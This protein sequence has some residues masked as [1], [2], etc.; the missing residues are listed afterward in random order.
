M[1]GDGRRRARRKMRKTKGKGEGGKKMKAKG[2]I[3]RKGIMRTKERRYIVYRKHDNGTQ[4]E[5]A[6]RQR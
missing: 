2:R 5:A 3:R 1:V 4:T 6:D